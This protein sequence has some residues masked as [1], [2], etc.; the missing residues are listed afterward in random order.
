ME[1]AAVKK[2][3]HSRGQIVEKLKRLS[4]F[5]E[6]FDLD[7][8]NVFDLNSRFEKIDSYYDEFDEIQLKIEHHVLTLL[9]NEGLLIDCAAN[10]KEF[11]DKYFNLKS[12]AQSILKTLS[13][14]DDPVINEVPH[15]P[16][17]KLPI[18]SLPNFNGECE[19]WLNF[20]EVF[21]SLIHEN[22]SLSEIQKFFYLR[23]ALKDEASRS[24]QS[25]EITSVN[26]EIAWKLIKERFENKKMIIK[27]HVSAIIELPHAQKESSSLLRELLDKMKSHITTL[28]K[29]GQPIEHWDTFIVILLANKFDSSTRREWES[30]VTAGDL[31]TTE[32]IFTFIK[33]RCE[34]LEAL[35]T[36]RAQGL[37]KAANTVR[38]TALSSSESQVVKCKMCHQN[39]QIYHCPSF[40]N[41]QAVERNK[42]V[43]E[44]KLCF[45]CL[46]STHQTDACKSKWR[47]KTC[48]AAHNS[49]LHC[50]YSPLSTDIEAT[51][52]NIS[53]KGQV[54]HNFMNINNK[55]VFLSTAVVLA[56]K[57]SGEKVHA[58]CS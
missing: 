20:Y 56:K 58:V 25:M 36:H 21:N 6:Q 15:K 13:K 52:S 18:I 43:Q 38:T 16:Q 40:I 22:P 48:K 41:L 17:L 53:T 4:E 33:K 39:H 35:E 1:T 31:P 47:C 9:N 55:N 23:S 44:L 28:Q 14:K 11:E 45:N 54:S 37:K 2:V 46:Q 19:N 29:L 5:V 3:L 8:Q 49:L 57:A 24:I 51:V 7:N 30:T 42:K 34:I 27:K 32:E 10:R 12:S 50:E 26:Y